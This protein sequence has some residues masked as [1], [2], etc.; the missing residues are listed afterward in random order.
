MHHVWLK[1]IIEKQE[2][3]AYQLLHRSKKSD[4]NVSIGHRLTQVIDTEAA[5]F[6]F[7]L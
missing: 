3:A 7:Y 2:V 4:F 1:T 6:T 5:L